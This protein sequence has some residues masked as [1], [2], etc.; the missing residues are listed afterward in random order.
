MFSGEF[1]TFTLKSDNYE[2]EDLLEYLAFYFVSPQVI[3]LIN[4]LTTG[5]TKESRARFKEEQFLKLYVPIPKTEE[6]FLEI[7]SSIR[8]INQFKKDI[9]KLHDRLDELPISYRSTFP[10][11]E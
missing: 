3:S 7:V 5:S 1:P 4:R 10:F 6:I 11:K 2:K 9:R 8:Q